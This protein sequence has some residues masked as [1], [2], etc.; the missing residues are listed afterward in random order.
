VCDG[1]WCAKC[2]KQDALD[3]FPVLY[4]SDLEDAL[5]DPGEF[6]EDLDPTRFKQARNGDHLMCPFQCDD[7]C[8]EN[9][10]GRGPTECNSDKTLQITIRRAI[11]DSFWAREPSTVA[12]NLGEGVRFLRESR[13]LGIEDPYPPRGPFAVDDDFGMRTA[14][15]M[16][17]RS[18]DPGRNAAT[19]QH[20]TA[21]KVRSHVSNFVHTTPQ[22]VGPTLIS[23]GDRTGFYT[24]NSPTNSMWFNRFNGGCH[25]RMGDIWIPDVSLTI[26]ELL[27]CQEVL[28]AEWCDGVGDADRMMELALTGTMLTCGFSAGLRGEE[29]PL[30]DIGAIRKYWEEA[31]MHPRKPHIPIVLAGRFKQRTGVKLYFQP[32]CKVSKSG[33]QNCRWLKRALGLYAEQGITEGPMFR[34][35]SKQGVMKRA[36]VSDLDTL[37]HDVLIS[38]QHHKPDVIDPA[39]DVKDVFGIRRSVRRGVTARAGNV[40]IPDDV[41]KAN[42]NWHKHIHSKGMVAGMTMIERYADAKASVEKLLKFSEGL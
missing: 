22:G 15:A 26:D 40:G 30:M 31:R 39:I 35:K 13:A 25:R 36:K 8:F 14:V 12:K 32:L 41:I 28:E 24:S 3:K 10:L 20:G 38:V 9:I 11:L 17:R 2:Y 42:N 5:M 1:A 19:I 18:L 4:A 34:T 27:A 29:V 33:I 7:C 21:R 6:A 16:L 23:T 37:F